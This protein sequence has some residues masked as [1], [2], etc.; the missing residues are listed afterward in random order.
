MHRL[1]RAVRQH[2]ETLRPTIPDTVRMILDALA[3]RRLAV[4]L[5]SLVLL[6]VLALMV[7]AMLQSDPFRA[8]QQL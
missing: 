3:R 7:G 8:V 4:F 6:L 5:S 2:Q 1:K